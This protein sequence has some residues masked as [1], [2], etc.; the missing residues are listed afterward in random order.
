ME[1]ERKQISKN[2]RR[3][4]EHTKGAAPPTQNLHH[5]ILKQSL[6]KYSSQKNKNFTDSI[7]EGA[8][9]PTQDLHHHILKQNLPKYSSQKNKN[10]TGSITEGVCSVGSNLLKRRHE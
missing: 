6:P 2:K 1:K 10:F 4:T 7:T 9:P 5:H 8:A 3:T